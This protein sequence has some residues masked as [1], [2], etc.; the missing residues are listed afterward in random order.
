M[1]ATKPRCA[2]HLNLWNLLKGWKFNWNQDFSSKCYS[3][4][5]AKG[6]L[7]WNMHGLRLRSA[8]MLISSTLLYLFHYISLMHTNLP[9]K[10]LIIYMLKILYVT[11]QITHFIVAH[12]KVLTL[13]PSFPFP[14]CPVG[15]ITPGSPG[16]PEGPAGPGLP[17]SPWNKFLKKTKKEGLH[18]LS[19]PK[20]THQLRLQKWWGVFAFHIIFCVNWWAFSSTSGK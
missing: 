8:A 18:W 16:G 19:R 20:Q 9:L 6:W 15:P 4:F 12:I 17:A 14:G 1:G 5:L 10:Q 11:S 13:S 2:A 3:C 7:T